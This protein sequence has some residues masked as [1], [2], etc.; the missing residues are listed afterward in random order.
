[1]LKIDRSFVVDGDD[2]R[3]GASVLLGGI[4]QLGTGLGMQIVAEGSRR[5]GRRSGCARPAATWGRASCG[6]DR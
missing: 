6:R 5:P 1:M 4:A 2:R 3:G